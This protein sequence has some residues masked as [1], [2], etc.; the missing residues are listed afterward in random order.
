VTVSRVQ[1]GT[2][3]SGTTATLT[4][5]ATLPAPAT[6]GNAL[7][8]AVQTDKNA[9]T[10]TAP[11]GFTELGTLSGADVSIGV[12]GKVAA[13]GEQTVTAQWSSAVSGQ[14]AA[15]IEYTGTH[16]SAPFGVYNLPPYTTTSR[17]SMVLDLP[18]TPTPGRAVVYM[19]VDSITVDTPSDFAPVG[20]GFTNVVTVYAA[21]DGSAGALAYLEGPVLTAGQDLAATTFTWTRADQASGFALVLNEPGL[22]QAYTK[23]AAD[24]AAGADAA[25]R[26]LTVARTAGPDTAAGTDTSLALLTKVAGP[27]LAAGTDARS[28]TQ[29]LT[30]VLSDAAPVADV[31][32]S[33]LGRPDIADFQFVLDGVDTWMPFGFGQ[34][35][36]VATFDPGAAET[37]NQDIL[38]PVADVRYFGADRRT[39]PTW[40][41]DLYTDV[42]TTADALAWASLFEAVWDSDAIRSTPGAVLALRYAVAGRKRRVYGRPRNFAMV[43]TYVRTGRADLV[44]DFELADNTFYDDSL[45]TV[46]VRVRGTGTRTGTVFPIQFP[47][48]TLT[49]P[50]PRSEQVTIGGTRPTWVDLTFWGP[51]ID[52]WVTIGSQ[53][54]GL[55][56]SLASGQSVT[57]SGVPWRQGLLRSDGAW[58]PGM[59]DPRA[60]LSQLRLPPGTYT[61][62]L[63]GSPAS[64]QARVDVTWRN[65]YGT[66]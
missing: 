64:T 59:L 11:A 52:P 6:A 49:S 28:Y 21:G 1:Y 55:R 53:R 54:W 38:S 12:F 42:Q 60:R 58:V 20:T 47:L 46:S 26:T 23:T 45:G 16:P 35:I 24:T 25:A 15:L 31:V 10:W 50:A 48:A 66:M 43:P 32:T 9:G 19:A 63:G 17:S 62:T 29:A 7:V 57:M 56:G 37:R 2:T 14:N 4:V 27:D 3:G 8:M 61:A 18:A 30:R 33:E 65:A 40:S 44:A 51:I 5:A 22:P 41:F 34:T 13:G 39:P 36:V